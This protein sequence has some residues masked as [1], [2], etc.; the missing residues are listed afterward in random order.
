MGLSSA[1]HAAA[2]KPVA[3]AINGKPRSEREATFH[4]LGLDCPGCARHAEQALSA[5]EGVRA[6][7]VRFLGEL[8][9]VVYDVGSTSE[10]EIRLAMKRGGFR[11]RRVDGVAPSG[12][13][14][15]G[16][17]RVGL[18]TVLFVQLL[19]LAPVDLGNSA[20]TGLA[21]IRMV[22]AAVVLALGGYP[23]LR[24]AVRR[25]RDGM[26]G[27]DMLISL[28]AVG[29]FALGLVSMRGASAFAAFHGFETSAGIVVLA[30]LARAA[31]VRLWER[32]LV[33]LAD[34]E[35][36]R[37]S[38]AYRVTGDAVEQVSREALVV[39]DMVRIDSGAL[40]PA[41][42]R[43]HAAAHVASTTSSGR[44]TTETR[45]AGEVLASG[46]TLVS[47]TITAEI[48]RPYRAAMA[49]A[50]DAQVHRVLLR[51]DRERG[52]WATREGW[53]D[54]AAQAL[55][56]GVFTLA[57]FSLFAHA[58][59]G[60]GFAQPTPWFAAIAVLVMASPSAFV[61]A[62]PLARAIATVRARSLGI[63]VKEP[64]ALE[65]LAK[66]TT[67]C[68]EKNGTVTDNDRRVARLA[69]HGPT[70]DPSIL[71]DVLALES[72][73]SH[74]SGRA[75]A[76]YLRAGG[77]VGTAERVE[78]VHEQPG[79]MSG[80]VRG[81]LI[82]VGASERVNG[83]GTIDVPA[84]ASIA[85]F[86]KNGSAVG[87]FVLEDSPRPRADKALRGLWQR[88][89][90]CRILSG[91]RQ[92]GTQA[93][94]HRLGVTG[95][96]GLTD[97]DKALVV[98]ELQHAG[99]KVLYV[100]DG[101]SRGHAAAHAEVSIAVAS[102]VLPNAVA[103]PLL[104]VDPRLDR[105]PWLLDLA[106][107]LRRHLNAMA[108]VAVLFNATLVPLAAM[109]RLPAL[110]AAALALVETLLSLALAAHLLWWPRRPR[111]EA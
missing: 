17:L 48:V 97:A 13:V 18:S 83:A 1:E 35:R 109:G 46:N 89:L 22:F 27:S 28:A 40:V 11:L 67:A 19:A 82:E 50:V 6:A 65:A 98:R 94:A 66:V 91:D 8:A 105:L 56:A 26:V 49:A 38:T 81:A 61:L 7:S 107:S 76:G 10:R 86:S 54:V 62:A 16:R 63:L 47:A 14:G 2:S 69:W 59:L 9:Q 39:G 24:R 108:A 31:Y 12:R 111:E 70:P 95:T 51:I 93:I 15:Y 58:M 84:S 41:D 29:S 60:A 96:G 110:H 5:V 101:S 36:A 45:T 20:A 4:V 78:N 52:S 103:A 85:W 87:Y 37:L 42:A 92:E 44:T 57:I 102:S 75:I 23:M 64:H 71:A 100:W 30:Q 68:F 90:P 72:L 55:F 33:D 80:H 25:A 32:A 3:K 34:G 73:A 43:I 21:A 106:H 79:L 104:L 53:G 74:P 88:N 99:A 77:V